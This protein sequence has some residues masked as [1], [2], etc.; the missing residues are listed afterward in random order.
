MLLFGILIRGQTA[1]DKAGS[2]G[3]EAAGDHQQHCQGKERL[4]QE[5]KRIQETISN[6]AKVSRGWSRRL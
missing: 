2:G 3:Q 4:E 1:G 6:I 5:V